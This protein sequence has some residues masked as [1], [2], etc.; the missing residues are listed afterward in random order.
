[1]LA[2]LKSEI[3]RL[4][5]EESGVALMLTLSVFLLLYVVCAGVYSI[6]ETVRQKIELQNA[7]DN[8][9]YSAAVVQ[10]DGLSRIAM[11]N[12]ALSWTYVE[13][14]NMQMDYITY[15]F[16]SAVHWRFSEDFHARD[17]S[18]EAFCD[19]E[20][21]KLH[22]FLGNRKEPCGGIKKLK[23]PKVGWF[24]GVVGLGHEVVIV[25]GKPVNI[26]QIDRIVL[27]GGTDE[28]GIYEDY[29][30]LPGNL[31]DEMGDYGVK[32]E[33][34]IRKLKD[35]IGVFNGAIRTVMAD[36]PRAMQ[37]AAMNTLLENLPR[38]KAGRV[39]AVLGR[40]FIGHVQMTF[41]L[42]PYAKNEHGYGGGYFSPLYN[43]EL[44]ERL[45]LTMA[46]GEVY[47]TLP[48]YFGVGQGDV[49]GGLDQ[50]FIRSYPAETKAKARRV[51]QKSVL[52]RGS[53]SLRNADLEED[54]LTARGICRTYR[55]ANL[56]GLQGRD[57]PEVYRGHHRSANKWL[58][59][60]PD[61]FGPLLAEY[62]GNLGIDVLADD[63]IGPSCRNTRERFPEMCRSV[64]DSTALYAQYEWSS[65]KSVGSCYHVHYV[66]T[67]GFDI[68][69]RCFH[70]HGHET[71]FKETCRH[72]CGQDGDHARSE[73]KCCH[74]DEKELTFG[75]IPFD[76]IPF[77]Y[78][79]P[80]AGCRNFP[81]TDWK[82]YR[83]AVELSNTIDPNGF[84]R[85]YGDDKDICDEEHETYY[86]GAPAMPVVLNSLFYGSDGAVVVGLARRRRNPWALLLDGVAAAV[87]ND[88]SKAAGIYSA[89]D[90]VGPDEEYLVAFSAARAAHRFHP[91]ASGIPMAGPGEY[92]TRYD[93]VCEEAKFHFDRDVP[94][95]YARMQV[96]C[97]CNDQGNLN[98]LARCWNLCETDWDATLLPLRFAQSPTGTGFDSSGDKTDVF[99]RPGGRDRTS[100]SD[101]FG[102]N[103]YGLNP[104][105][106]AR[107]DVARNGV[108]RPWYPF[109]DA[110]GNILYASGGAEW[111]RHAV[112]GA[113]LNMPEP[114]SV[115]STG[116]VARDTPYSSMEI[117]KGET[118]PG[119]GI[120]NLLHAIENRI[121]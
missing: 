59:L 6:G 99:W 26:G 27:P 57:E 48:E 69:H 76:D 51:P 45:F 32:Y 100:G 103:M 62:S 120:L 101:V 109:F 114:P 55:N 46:D 75:G 16:L 61:V 49:A 41:P 82:A 77:V 60:A 12:R 66:V 35:L 19:A 8:A 11:L 68:E 73:Y 52:G 42:D 24:C 112:D 89:F 115:K 107:G 34:P 71:T 96:G 95:E 64:N 72:K 47:R 33:E 88:K 70:V 113:F 13:L 15:R 94:G 9:A 54:S 2:I 79:G 80:E 58:G 85:I 50:W 111:E 84:A 40:D 110:N 65:S 38:D 63:D 74:V 83:K 108:E 36:M 7:C 81:D 87:G 21:K 5:R 1:M 119:A 10:A 92:E 97:V 14:T 3:E 93:S 29:T 67:H 22:P 17:D 20:A 102:V 121:L 37:A 53:A 106:H 117:G 91:H 44:D 30:L 28:N 25:N 116:R 118:V 43:T 31:W 18:C 4:R 104:F 105:Q 39:D 56:V 78:D 23:E 90:P 98:R 86:C